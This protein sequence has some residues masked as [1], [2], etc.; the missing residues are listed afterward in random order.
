MT[1]ADL[2][3][4]L[5]LTLREAAA[6]EEP[7]YHRLD[8]AVPA[9]AGWTV[10]D[11]VAHLAAWRREAIELL[12]AVRKGESGRDF[13]DL[14]AHNAELYE[15]H[16]DWPAD[17]VRAEAAASYADFL[18]TVEDCP[19]E[20]LAG[21]RPGSEGRIWAWVL[22]NGHEHVAEHLTMLALESTD[23]AAADAVQAW[24]HAAGC[25]VPGNA[26]RADYNL[27]CY[28]A[29]ALRTEEALPPLRRALEADPS[30]REWARS[31]PDLES[32]RE[33]VTV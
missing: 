27:G 28:Y 16:R 5:L 12:G 32:V 24:A 4:E 6:R 17:R 29:R 18:Q 9:A 3:A 11:H 2:R 1:D 19:A 13:S 15:R 7:L 23:V 8:E 20:M 33:L 21:A 10:K 14:D 31:D 26:A 25:A 22:G 30:L